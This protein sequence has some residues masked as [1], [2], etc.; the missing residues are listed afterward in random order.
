MFAN[1]PR[2]GALVEKFILGQ[3]D[4]DH[5]VSFAESHLIRQRNPSVEAFFA[6]QERRFFFAAASLSSK[7]VRGSHGGVL[8]ALPS[9]LQL[10]TGCKG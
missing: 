2:W 3:C 8:A 10:G 4:D 9:S 6:S 5:V 7:S 1:I